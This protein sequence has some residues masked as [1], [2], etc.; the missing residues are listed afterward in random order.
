V[1]VIGHVPVRAAREEQ[2]P[3]AQQPFVPGV[4]TR[5][6]SLF[7]R[8]GLFPPLIA[9][10]DRQHLVAAYGR[11]TAHV[12]VIDLNDERAVRHAAAQELRYVVGSIIQAIVGADD[13][14]ITVSGTGNRRQALSLPGRSREAAVPDNGLFQYVGECGLPYF[15][16]LA[17]TLFIKVWRA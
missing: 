12:V 3:L 11:I 6:V 1:A 17:E 7:D 2:Y 9:I 8:R 13:L 4:S 14:Q 15:V 5:S 10:D 16:R